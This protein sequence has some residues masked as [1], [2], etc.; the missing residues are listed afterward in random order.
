MKNKSAKEIVKSYRIKFALLCVLYALGV[1]VGIFI[2]T[3]NPLVGIAAIIAL[4]ATLRQVFEK[5]TE[6]ELESVIYD[7]L[8]PIKLDEMIEL[9]MFKKS[10]RHK[11]LAALGRGDYDR[12]FALVEESQK[13]GANPVEQC[14][15]IYRKGAI[16]F[17][18]HDMEGLRKSVKEFAA[19][20]KQHPK[21]SAVFHNYTVFEKF[22]AMVDEDYE[23]V[24]EA[25][26]V[27]LAE[28]NPKVQNHKMTKLNVSF[29]RAVAL[30]DMGRLAE[31]KEAFE[32]IIAFAP[33]MHKATISREYIAKIEQNS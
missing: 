12:V 6:K 26:E 25:C 29:Y 24:I 28:V 13:N 11:A 30:Y 16:C 4:A 31:A 3:V 27:D 5:L 21:L 17:E 1:G 33:K 8:D 14:N 23:Y 32:E 18:Q 9:G 22:D 2:I 7:E 20:K 15:N 10:I 19:L